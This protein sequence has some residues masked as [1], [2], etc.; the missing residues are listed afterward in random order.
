MDKRAKHNIELLA[1]PSDISDLIVSRRTIHKFLPT[2]P[3]KELLLESID[4]ARWAPNHKLTEPWRFYLIGDETRHA[5]A[6]LVG[7]YVRELKGEKSA[8]AKLKKCL[9]VPSMVVVTYKKSGNDFREKEDYAATCCAIHNMSLHLWE[10]GVGM[11]WSTAKVMQ[12]ASFYEL[13]A[14]DPEREETVGILWCGYPE[15]VPTKSR[16]PVG[17][18]V[19]ELP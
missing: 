9:D 14:I 19:R 18:I 5:I 8:A 11:K 3:S 17:A 15:D 4:V 16:K 1:P 10:K 13:L 2:P 12:H 7:D 6:N